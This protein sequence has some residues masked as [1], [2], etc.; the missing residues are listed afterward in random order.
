ME[1]DKLINDWKDLKDKIASLQKQSDRYKY[2]IEN[3]MEKTGKS[4]I[5]GTKYTVKKKYQQNNRMIKKNI[6]EDIW[7]KY[8]TV[9]T[10]NTIT[11]SKNK[12]KT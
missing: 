12:T 9:I 2:K 4:I 7:D 11:F 8:S 5:K 10:Y 1:H 3:I 6:P